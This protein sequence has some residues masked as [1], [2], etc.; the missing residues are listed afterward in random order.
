MKRADRAEGKP[1]LLCQ[2]HL[3]GAQAAATAASCGIAVMAKAS[4]PGRAKTRLVPPLTFELAAALNTAFLKDVAANIALA[5]RHA[6]IGAAI[7]GYAAYGP[8][9]S[10]PFFRATFAGTIGLIPAWLPDFGDCL[11][12]AIREIFARGHA[13]AVVLNADS[14]TLPTALLNMTAEILAR[15]GDRAVLGPS[16]DGGYYLLGLKAAHQ[17]MFEDIAW[18]TE[19]VG[20]QTR[21]RASEIGLDVEVLPLWY[22]VD[23]IDDLRLLHAQLCRN[24]GAPAGGRLQPHQAHHSK[25]LLLSVWPDGEFSGIERRAP[26][27]PAHA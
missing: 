5:A 20:E 22:D 27:A 24:T 3:S 19:R 2:L 18:S 4:A 17:R 15:P 8:P 7:A 1:S 25:A 9:G 6:R 10:E 11:L 16:S 26:M 14:P 12:H 13:S 21:A 23:D